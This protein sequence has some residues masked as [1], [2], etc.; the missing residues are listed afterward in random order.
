ML[1]HRVLGPCPP[2]LLS[3]VH[4]HPRCHMGPRLACLH[5]QRMVRLA[6]ASRL[7]TIPRHLYL[8]AFPRGSGTLGTTRH[9][10]DPL[11]LPRMEHLAGFLN[12][13]PKLRNTASALLNKRSIM[14]TRLARR[15]CT[16]DDKSRSKP[17]RMDAG[18]KNRQ[19]FMG[20]SRVHTHLVIIQVNLPGTFPRLVS[21]AWLCTTPRHRHHLP[22]T[23]VL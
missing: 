3:Q 6:M 23:R 11:A 19:G 17:W 7:N 8:Q 12:S 21:L 20:G 2:F 14:V 13:H 18:S 22:T 5:S 10:L 15:R 16:T 9:S 1:P 4:H